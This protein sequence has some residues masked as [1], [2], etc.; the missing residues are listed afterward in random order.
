MTLRQLA[1]Q[2]TDVPIPRHLMLEIL[3]NYKR[4]NDKISELISKGELI[5]VKRGLY[6]PGKNS[7]LN[8]PESFIIANHLWGPSY[9]SLETAMAFWNM[10]PERVHEVS[11]ATLKSARKYETPVGRFTYFHL[12]KEYYALGI[13]KVEILPNQIALFASPE[14]AICDKIVYTSGVKLR[15]VKQTLECLIDDLRIDVATLSSLNVSLFESW[16]QFAPKKDSL[17]GLIKALKTL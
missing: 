7:G 16:V 8:V 5:A 2:S 6:I 12:P 3:K 15:S 11:S 9:I 4:P 17:S 1:I 13:Q 10:I 14:K